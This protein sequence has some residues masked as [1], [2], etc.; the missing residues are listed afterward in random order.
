MWTFLGRSSRAAVLLVIIIIFIFFGRRSRYG[1]GVESEG[2]WG[3]RN[4]GQVGVSCFFFFVLPRHEKV[5]DALWRTLISGTRRCIWSFGTGILN[6]R[7]CELVLVFW[8][9]SVRVEIL[10]TRGKETLGRL[11]AVFLKSVLVFSGKPMSWRAGLNR[12]LP[13]EH[14]KLV[15][16][17]L[18]WCSCSP[19]LML[20]SEGLIA[21]VIFLF[22]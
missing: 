22:V 16:S 5:L 21:F 4:G 20:R 6:A 13:T 14:P 15:G 11:L 18:C 8:G 19:Q 3:R 9:L 12:Y 2:I 7:V 1:D 17:K 10:L